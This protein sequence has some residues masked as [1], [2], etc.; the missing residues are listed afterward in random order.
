MVLLA[1]AFLSM[2]TILVALW[3]TVASDGHGVRPPP[4]SHHDVDEVDNQGMPTKYL[5]P[6]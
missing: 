3:R 2:G 5:F 6:R 1:L 4:R